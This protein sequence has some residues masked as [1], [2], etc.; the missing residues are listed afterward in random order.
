MAV[1]L[2]QHKAVLGES[3]DERQGLCIGHWSVAALLGSKPV[4][5]INFESA[6]TALLLGVILDNLQTMNATVPDLEFP[7]RCST[8]TGNRRG[9]LTAAEQH[10]VDTY[11][12]SLQAAM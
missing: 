6:I 8:P 5:R 2:H 4:S 3:V 10:I 1:A 9:E 11:P 12:E 7:S